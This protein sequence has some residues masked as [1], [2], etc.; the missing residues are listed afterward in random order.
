MKIV[1]DSIALGLQKYGGIS[2]YWNHL[3]DGVTGEYLEKKY[4]T[5]KFVNC[6]SDND[7]VIEKTPVT[8]S[9]YLPVLN[10]ERDAI[11]HTSYYRWPLTKCKAYI[12]T[13]YDYT[14]ERFSS[15]PQKWVHSLQKFE[16]IRRADA[17]ICISASTRNDLLGYCRNIDPEK[18]HVVH[19]GVD[20]NKFY[21]DKNNE[22]IE[23]HNNEVLFI[24]R[25][26]GYKRFDLA[27]KALNKID[28]LTLTIVGPTLTSDEV[29]VLNKFLPKRWKSF[30]NIDHDKLRELY[31]SSFAFM[32][33]S[34]YEGF[35]LP[36]LES[37]A[38][39]CPVISSSLSSLPEVGGSAVLYA[40]NQRPESY[41]DQLHALIESKDLR[42]SLIR[43]G[44]DHSKVFTWDR[45]VAE[46]VK[47]YNLF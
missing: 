46:T 15:P 37:M 45:T 33:P 27:I 24:G 38:C 21:C 47:I 25:R 5:P 19:L 31:A 6:N 39:G 17:V 34:D 1:F 10:V 4:I 22:N 23:E 3:V 28:I 2:N 36:L 43:S 11:F 40:E 14:Y 16:S 7:A 30:E 13:V 44:L 8:I 35:G 12:V 32:F 26:S 42:N 41:S 18:V 9:R 29:R 20:H